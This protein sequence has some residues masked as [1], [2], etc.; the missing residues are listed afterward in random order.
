LDWGQAEPGTAAEA[1]REEVPQDAASRLAFRQRAQVKAAATQKAFHDFR[2]TDRTAESGI[3]FRSRAV[4]DV[5]KN[6]KPIHYD[7]G[8]G[9]AV[10]DIDGDGL[11]DIYFVSQLGGNELWRNLG[12]GKFENITASAGVGLNDRICV[13]AS[14]AD[15]DN[16][17]LP[18]LFVTTVR[19]GNVL[20][21]NL[22]N[23]KFRDISKEAG[24][25]YVGHSS[26]AVFFDFDN[27]GLLDLFVC[28][29]GKYT[30]N[31]RGAGGY[32]VGIEKGFY[33]HLK[34]EL[35]ERSLL[36]RN[37]GN[38]K[39]ELLTPEVL[40]HVA[41]SGDAS[42]ADVNGDGYPDLYVLNMQG[43]DHFYLNQGG[44]K[45]VEK[46]AEYFPKTPWG[47]M[48][49][50]FFDFNNDGRLDLYITDMHSDMTTAQ[51]QLQYSSRPGSEK[52][53][54]EQ[55]CRVEWTE[56]YLRGS[57]NNIFGNA[58][59]KNLGGGKYQEV[60]DETA[61]ETWW[62]WGPSVG[63][64]NADGYPDI[65]VTAGMGYPYSY[66]ANSVLLNE[67][68][69]RFIDS[70]FTLGLEPRLGWRTTTDYF[71]LDCAGADK[72]HPLCQGQTQRVMIEGTV[73]SRSAALV[74]LDNDGDLD[75]I[76][77][78]IN[79]R[80]QILLS[81]LSDKK[82]IHYLKIKLTG[83]KSN[84][85]ALGAVVKLT[86]GGV[87][88]TQQND[89]KSGYLSQS[90]IPLYFGLGEATRIDRIEVAWPSGKKQLLERNI[91]PNTLLSI[92]EPR[93]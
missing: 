43:S 88:Q 5:G 75:I 82:H 48:G 62:P 76:T 65:F 3:S 39:F 84:R 18:D 83:T 59:W 29:V 37:L 4:D 1:T 64:L 79:D 14:F 81:N 23:G 45:F 50:K 26:G 6:N 92:V 11:P 38:C 78:E 34:P 72:N 58:L 31:E 22:G 17:G 46:T 87:T 16:D 77:N 49:I 27:D 24:V 47:A 15:I 41:W 20:F 93:E 56:E 74:D 13:G 32:Y 70:E 12:N 90:S 61:A 44:R 33:S 25:D 89:G 28:N 67:G 73:S 40:D 53:K 55:F 30:T 66:A 85:D 60:S 19:G 63:D 7:H 35:S 69:K 10:A 9:L 91:T 2:F 86:A 51:I 52:I 21:H 42:F 57:S 8:C 36:Y 80:P 71:I 54:S 68:G